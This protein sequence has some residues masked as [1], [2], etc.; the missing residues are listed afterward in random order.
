MLMCIKVSN[1]RLLHLNEMAIN[2][3]VYM[4]SMETLLNTCMEYKTHAQVRNKKKKKNN[5]LKLRNV[6]SCM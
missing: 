2:A 3:F 1:H 5:E 4:F 6:V